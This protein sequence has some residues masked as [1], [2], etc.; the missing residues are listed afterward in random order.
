VPLLRSAPIPLSLHRPAAPPAPLVPLSFA[1]A[2]IHRDSALCPGRS[3]KKRPH[4]CDRCGA[5]FGQKC[6]LQRH[7]KAVH[8]D[9]DVRFR[10]EHSACAWAFSEYRLLQAH[11]KQF[12]D[13]APP[14]L[15]RVEGCAATFMWAASH[16]AH[17]VDAHGA[18]PPPAEPPG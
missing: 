14:F 10:C 15:C 12:H 11:I 8:H 4:K 1:R 7:V 9:A 6:S 5:N 16:R 13:G 3:Q 2:K 17:M 18:D